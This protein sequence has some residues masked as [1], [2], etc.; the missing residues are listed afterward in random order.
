MSEHRRPD[1]E[2]NDKA[3]ELQQ[4]DLI[5]FLILFVIMGLAIVAATIFGEMI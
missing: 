2:E 4:R 5:W 3:G 1:N